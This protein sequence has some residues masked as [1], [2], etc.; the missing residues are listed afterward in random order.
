[1]SRREYTEHDTRTQRGTFNVRYECHQSDVDTLITFTKGEFDVISVRV[2][3]SRHDK[4]VRLV[5]IEC[6]IRRGDE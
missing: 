6:K 1:M 2:Y 3:V 5:Y 4:E